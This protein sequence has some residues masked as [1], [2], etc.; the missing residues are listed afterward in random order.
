M[1][2]LKI[3][4]FLAPDRAA[5]RA[6]GLLQDRAQRIPFK[7]R[8][9]SDSNELETDELIPNPT[10]IFAANRPA[11]FRNWAGHGRALRGSHCSATN[12]MPFS[13]MRSTTWVVEI[14]RSVSITACT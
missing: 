10:P 4:F 14:S 5:V 11:Y 9:E 1:H 2:G 7:F 8:R 12:V 3:W 13:C 6:F